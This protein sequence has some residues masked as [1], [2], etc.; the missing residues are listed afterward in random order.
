MKRFGGI[1]W[2]YIFKEKPS[3]HTKGEVFVCKGGYI[4]TATG[5]KTATGEEGVY[6][7]PVLVYID[8]FQIDYFSED[9]GENDSFLRIVKDEGG[10]GFPSFM[11]DYVL[12][13]LQ[14]NE[15][16]PLLLPEFKIAL[17]TRRPEEI[18][19]Y[20]KAIQH[21]LEDDFQCE[22]DLHESLRQRV[23]NCLPSP[24][25]D[26]E[27]AR[28]FFQFFIK[29][30]VVKLS[31]DGEHY[32]LLH[33]YTPEDFSFIAKKAV[34]KDEIQQLI[35]RKDYYKY[36]LSTKGERCKNNSRFGKTQKDLNGKRT[37]SF[38]K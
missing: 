8:G 33:Q 17:T 24:E 26:K 1:P 25:N 11:S 4:P 29:Q 32:I 6:Y 13:Y 15:V 34:D 3:F 21:Y 14:K 31:E 35:P 12:E 28:R 18:Q 23:I 9:S 19:V 37:P 7:S 16:S 5:E 36:V 22:R 2:E 20:I 38:M 27:K 10:T 30:K